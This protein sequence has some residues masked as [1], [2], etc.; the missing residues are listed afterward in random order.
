MHS[1]PLYLFTLAIQSAVGGCIMLMLYNILLKN[2][3][4]K[5]TLQKANLKSLTALTVLSVLGLGCSFFDI[6]YPLNAVNA[7]TNLGASWLSREILFTVLFIA[8]ISV[9]LAVN[10]KT[11]HLSQALLAVAGIAGLAVIFAMGSL[12]SHTIFEPWNSLNTLIG[13][14]GS[15]IIL[16]AVLISLVFFPVFKSTRG[17]FEAIKLPTLLAVLAAFIIQFAFIAALG[18]SLA[19]L[20]PAMSLVRWFC[21]ALAALLLVYL[22][23]KD[24][25]K[26]ELLY[27][28]F[29]LLLVGELIGR[30]LFYLPLS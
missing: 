21:S 22:Y 6:G 25:K 13:F 10:W 29:G 24:P 27:I 20:N 26:S 16:G 4:A 14:Y 5:D 2:I 12:Y 17:S 15:T 19:T 28:S 30:Y 23:F 3:V 18:S 7:I 8:L 1:W 9:S 11:Q